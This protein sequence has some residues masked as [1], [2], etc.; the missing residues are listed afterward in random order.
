MSGS[1][2]DVRVERCKTTGTENDIVECSGS[3]TLPDG[4][5]RSGPVERADLEDEGRTI[6]GRATATRATV[7]TGRQVVVGVLGMPAP[8]PLGLGVIVLTVRHVLR[9]PA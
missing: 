2:V 7:A 4:T 8:V 9:P 5:H 1:K 6:P 3:W